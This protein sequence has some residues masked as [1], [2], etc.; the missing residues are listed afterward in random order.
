MAPALTAIALVALMLVSLGMQYFI[1]K[2]KAMSELEVRQENELQVASLET[3]SGIHIVKS[4]LLEPLRWTHYNSRTQDVANTGYRLLRNQSRMGAIQEV[5]QFALIGLIVFVGVSIFDTSLAVIIALLFT[6][7]RLAPMVSQLNMQ[8]ARFVR[9]LAGVQFVNL[10]MRNMA[11]AEIISGETPFTGLQ[12]AIEIQSVNFSY[13]GGAEVL[14]GASFTIEK[15]KTTAIVGTSGSGKSTIIDMILRFYDPVQGS[16]EVDGV[17]LRDLDLASWRRSI[18]VV[19]QEVF[20][21]NDTVAYNIGVSRTDADMEE[22]VDAAKQAYAHDFIQQLSDGY[23]TKIGDR[24]WNLSGGQRQ[25]ISLARAILKKPEIL[26]LDEATSALDSESEQLI[27][28][29]MREIR[30]SCTMVV[31]AHRTSTIQDA[32]KVVVLQDGVIAEE[33][34]W[35]TLSAGSGL[36]ASYHRLQAGE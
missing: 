5:A 31:V 35:D 23:E 6:L 7:Y 4:F 2:A 34:D 22:I 14:R 36:L 18:G 26:I 28:D 1:A 11:R 24:G 12:R 20:L 29:Y 27:Q 15:G 10:A 16:I 25:R 32:D 21:F 33:G 9:T 17:D 19:T 8:R 30:K 3:L 13:N